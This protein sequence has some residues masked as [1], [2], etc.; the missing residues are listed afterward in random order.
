M[1]R[2]DQAFQIAMTALANSAQQTATIAHIAA[3]HG[4]VSTKAQKQV[5]AIAFHHNQ[6]PET[7]ALEDMTQGMTI[8]S[9]ILT[10]LCYML[11]LL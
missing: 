5:N 2:G 8:T 3:S 7:V 6:P 9:R 10:T 1:T 11:L 4:S